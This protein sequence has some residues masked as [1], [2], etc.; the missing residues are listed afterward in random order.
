MFTRIFNSIRE[1]GAK[2]PKTPTKHS[3]EEPS[4]YDRRPSVTE[5]CEHAM[6]RYTST[7][8]PTE[9]IPINNRGRRA[10]V[11]GISNVAFD[12]YVQKDLVSSSWS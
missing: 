8:P 10:T 6:S 2:N 3:T 1:N 5:E 7:S 12:D 11:F 9:P 4:G